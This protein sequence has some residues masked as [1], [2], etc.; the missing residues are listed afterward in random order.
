MTEEVLGKTIVINKPAYSLYSAFSD[1]RN[2]VANL[3]QE[4]KDKIT[5]DAD[6]ISTTVQGLNI[7]VKVHERTPFSKIDFE[8]FG[9]APFSFLFTMFME[10]AN[11]NSTYFHI[12]LRAELNTIM[13]MIVGGKMQGFVDKITD[14]IA[15]AAA[16]QMPDDLANYVS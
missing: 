5:A 7:G 14:Q 15:Q 4:Q 12:E 2:L 6:T 3:P 8:Q 11:D 13:K 16:G 10:P 1:L 9:Q